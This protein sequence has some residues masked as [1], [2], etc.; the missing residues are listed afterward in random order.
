MEVPS[1]PLTPILATNP[2]INQQFS[3]PS[4]FICLHHL[5]RTSAPQQ[6]YSMVRGNYDGGSRSNSNTSAEF[7]IIFFFM[8]VAIGLVYYFYRKWYLPKEA[9]INSAKKQYERDRTF[10]TYQNERQVH[11][12]E[13]IQKSVNELSNSVNQQERDLETIYN[14]LQQVSDVLNEQQEFI[15][16]DNDDYVDDYC[17]H[18][19][20]VEEDDD[21]YF[22]K[23]TPVLSNK[24]SENAT[25]EHSKVKFIREGYIAVPNVLQGNASQTNNQPELFKTTSA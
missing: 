22:D 25:N 10:I 14:E 17:N 20:D 11:L 18:D 15:S 19:D 16:L 23:K 1:I 2:S 12:L 9:E 6:Q 3:D 8:F 13:N 24:L 4:K 21:D 7:F 5:H